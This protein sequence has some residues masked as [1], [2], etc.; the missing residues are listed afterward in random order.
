MI[1]QTT[2]MKPFRRKLTDIVSASDRVCVC[3]TPFGVCSAAHVDNMLSF[4]LSKRKQSCTST[5]LFSF[6][7]VYAGYRRFSKMVWHIGLVGGKIAML[8]ENTYSCTHK[9][10]HAHM[11]TYYE[12]SLL[13]EYERTYGWQ[14]SDWICA[15]VCVR[16]A[17]EC[18]CWHVCVNEWT[19]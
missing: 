12:R 4:F 1:L 8:D 10:T 2:E 17:C 15:S 13:K 3:V 18:A 16:S 5:I 7:L 19:V 11:F 9:S 6:P 14:W